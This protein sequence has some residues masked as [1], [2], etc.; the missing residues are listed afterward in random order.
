MA[1]KPELIDLRQASEMLG[2]TVQTL[3]RW[4]KQGRLTYIKLGPKCV[5]V[6]RADVE[7]FLNDATFAGGT[8]A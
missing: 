5:R 1:E 7:A 6:R 2:V 3:R 8:L 4:C